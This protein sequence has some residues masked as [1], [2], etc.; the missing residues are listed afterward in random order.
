MKRALTLSTI[1]L[2]SVAGALAAHDL[3]LKPAAFFVT[4]GAS[5]NV[6]VLNGTFTTSENSVSRDRLRDL[7]L[8]GPSGRTAL[9]TTM[10]DTTG[11]ASSIALRTSEAGT[12]MLAASLRTR[13]IKLEAKEFNEYLASDGVND[14]LAA[15]RRSGETGLAARERYSKHVK[16][17]FQVGANRTDGFDTVLGYPAELVPLDNPYSVRTGRI[18]R[19]RAL[20]DG[21]PV[22]NQ[23]VIAGGRTPA[24][25][26][27]NP[28]TVRTDAD[29]TAR[30]RISSRGAWYVK[31]INMQRARGDTTIDYESKWATLTFGVR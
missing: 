11:T 18:L 15:R 27:I 25:S 13:E 4:P 28:Q 31:F 12:Y 9:D 22:P 30:V 10:W 17:V 14:V 3:F 21:V 6:R 19:V 8:L 23:I 7:S 29:G 20:T 16:A 26:R 2:V 24:G 1:L 5:V